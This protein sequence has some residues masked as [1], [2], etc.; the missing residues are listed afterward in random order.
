[1]KK[2]LVEYMSNN[3]VGNALV[4]ITLICALL[5]LVWQRKAEALTIPWTVEQ[6]ANAIYKAEGGAKT[7]HPYGILSHYK[8][9]TP[10]QAC[11]NTINH[12][13]KDWNGNG[14]F[15]VF[16]G[17]RYCPPTAHPLNR[18]W[19]KN[20]HY[21]LVNSGKDEDDSDLIEKRKLSYYARATR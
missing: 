20:V 1:M 13:L 11:I 7:L 9:T 18:N 5:V 16:L 8:H 6:I 17:A 21:F 4:F 19:V 2:Y 12:A 15:I 3:S 10:R 14:D